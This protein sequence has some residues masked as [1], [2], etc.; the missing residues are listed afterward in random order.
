MMTCHQYF[1]FNVVDTF[2]NSPASRQ[3]TM[4]LGSGIQRE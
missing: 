1:A 4:I 3:R 2:Q